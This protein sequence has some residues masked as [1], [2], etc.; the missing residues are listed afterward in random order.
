MLKI[1]KTIKQIPHKS[2]SLLFNNFVFV[3]VKKL[4]SNRSSSQSSKN[5]STLKKI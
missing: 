5:V 2:L 1:T 3:Y 4:Y